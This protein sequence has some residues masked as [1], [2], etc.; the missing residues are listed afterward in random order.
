MKVKAKPSK[1]IKDL[2]TTG[3][4][5]LGV[6]LFNVLILKIMTAALSKEYFGLFILMRRWVTVLVPILTL[7]LSIALTR[8]VSYEKENAGF[9]LHISLLV[10]TAVS[11]IVFSA[12]FLFPQT[13]AGLFFKNSAFNTFVFILAVFLAAN[14]IE[15]IAYSYFRGKLNMNTA[16]ALR[17]LFYGFPV[18]LALVLMLLKIKNH[19]AFLYL[20]FLIYSLWGVLMG[21]WYLRR[22]FS[23]ALLK[24]I[25]KKKWQSLFNRSRKLFLF[26]FIRIPSVVFDSLIF[27]FPVFIAAHK[28]SITAAGYM[29]I[30]VAVLRL[31][32]MFSMPFNMIFLP[33]FSSL[34]K[35]GDRE[36]IK[37]YS[38]LVLDFI[39]TFLPVLVVTV[40]GLARFI[41][42]IWVGPAYLPTAKSVA[43]AVLFSMFYLAFALI[44]GILDGLFVFPF[45]N[46]IGLS[47]FVTIAGLS[48]AL[49]TDVFRLSI[50][51]GC[52]LL[53]LGL[54]SIGILVK[55]LHLSIPWTVVLKAIACTLFIFLA[56]KAAD[57][58]LLGLS[59]KDL[60][61]FAICVSYR[62][63]LVSVVWFFYWRKTL[64]YR[65]LIKRFD[66]SGTR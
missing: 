51:F 3:F 19:A 22:E 4:S 29:G 62:I 44:R 63:L 2:F 45:N 35:N 41:I 60:H 47:G 56:L 23:F 65:E 15:L 64:W 50:A 58:Y 9:Y 16:N 43:V 37:N 57:G 10:S 49:G 8:Y 33:K 42:L 1:F 48:L 13:F 61:F 20:Y 14:Y 32:E 18:L 66:F 27:S 5:Q 54:V 39:F 26:S 38:L 53:F 55:K 11:A 17:V 7:N 36:N 21:C 59:L 28:I 30:V 24:N 34:E 31:L 52:G 46:F 25:L 40:F 12:F 6:L